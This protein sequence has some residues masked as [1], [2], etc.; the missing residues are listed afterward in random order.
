MDLGTGTGVLSFL[1][2]KAGAGLCRDHSDFISVARAVAEHNGIGGIT[3][4]KS[5]SREFTPGEKVD[6]ILHDQMG[7]E[8]FNE[9][10]LENILDLKRRLL[11]TSGRII[12][13][14]FDLFLEPVM[15]REDH[16]A[17]YLW[18]QNVAGVDF[19]F[20]RAGNL[21]EPFKSHNY[22]RRYIDNASVSAFLCE[23][24]R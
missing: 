21:L 16:R 19:G 12:P 4:V 7:D 23:P 15:L 3:F 9:N 13:A 24:V 18:E 2:A 20:L 11:K 14:R 8:L 6:V 1:A 17:P 10:M 5:A 22:G